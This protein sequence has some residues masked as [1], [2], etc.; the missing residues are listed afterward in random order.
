VNGAIRVLVGRTDATSAA[1]VGTTNDDI[2]L[3]YAVHRK[4]VLSSHKIVNQ[5]LHD[6]SKEAATRIGATA[7]E[8]ALLLHRE[9]ENVDSDP[10]RATVARTPE[11]YLNL[12]LDGNALGPTTST[13]ILPAAVRAVLAPA[14]LRR[15]GARAGGRTEPEI[16]EVR[17]RVSA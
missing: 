6:K 11:G 1:D 12:M 17:G 16:S 14:M 7:Y 3:P 5:C 4:I 2:A 9:A 13:C 8:L 10:Q 15:I